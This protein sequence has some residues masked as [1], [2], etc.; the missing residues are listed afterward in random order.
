MV[1][2]KGLSFVALPKVENDPVMIR[3]KEVVARLELQKALAADPQHVR[4]VKVKGVEKTSKIQ[5]MWRPMPDG[6]FCFVLRVG[7][8]PIEFAPGKSAIAVPS[9]DKLP[10]IIDTLIGAVR[11]GSLDDKIK[12]AKE[13]TILSSSKTA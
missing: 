8:K 4:T 3:R 2:L 13:T 12:P 10:G 1:I 6:S 11:D 9:L 5:P 7:F